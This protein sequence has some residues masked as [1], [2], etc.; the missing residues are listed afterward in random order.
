MSS[1][2]A[3]KKIIQ[4][5]GGTEKLLRPKTSHK[6]NKLNMSVARKGD[7]ILVC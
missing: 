3:V 1:P 5:E 2:M 7:K 6:Q 4:S